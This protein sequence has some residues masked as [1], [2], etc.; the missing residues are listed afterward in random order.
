MP[1]HED[2]EVQYQRALRQQGPVHPST[3]EGLSPTEGLDEYVIEPARRR[4]R[5]NAEKAA[6]FGKGPVAPST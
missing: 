2:E 6:R 3:G 5:I 1:Q 4:A